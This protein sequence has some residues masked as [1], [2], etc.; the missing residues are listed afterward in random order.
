MKSAFRKFNLPLERTITKSRGITKK[1]IRSYNTNQIHFYTGG[2]LHANSGMKVCML[3]GNSPLAIRTAAHI[4]P[5][6]TPLNM[7]HRTN[8]DT[9]LPWGEQRLL[10]SSNPFNASN[11]HITEYDHVSDELHKMR[12]W[13]AVGSRYFSYCPDI[14]NEWDLENAIKDCDVIINFIGSR[15][16][17][18]YDEDYDEANVIIPRKVAQMCAKLKG[19][20]VKR[21]IHFSAAGAYP[22]A[23]SRRLRTKWL[24]EQEVKLNFPEA[25]IIRPTTVLCNKN[26]DFI[27]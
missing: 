5:M 8:I 1:T 23:V 25:T 9:E 12:S 24:G 11:H 19:N 2:D 21:L 22:D 27:S 10:K 13:G 4:L 6:G 17:I 7:V 3:G 15:S 14:T 18:R 16:V 26:S 20:P